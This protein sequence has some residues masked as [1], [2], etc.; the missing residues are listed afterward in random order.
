ML[1]ELDLLS[2]KQRV[3]YNTLKL[4]YKAE[5]KRLPDYL[6]DLFNYVSEVQPYSLRTNNQFRLPDYMSAASQNSIL[7]KGVKLYND[8]KR[9]FVITEDIKG[10]N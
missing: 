3:S 4:I 2:V 5:Y 7:Y 1:D 6:C 9:S 8:L 10:Y